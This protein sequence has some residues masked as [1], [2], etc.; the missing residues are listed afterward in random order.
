MGCTSSKEGSNVEGASSKEAPNLDKYFEL[1]VNE[2]K[3]MKDVDALQAAVDNAEDMQREHRETETTLHAELKPIIAAAFDHHDTKRNGILDA[4]ESKVFFDH[5]LTRFAQCK[6]EISDFSAQESQKM[7]MRMMSGCLPQGE[8]GK[9]MRASMKRDAEGK[10]KEMNRI[11]DD[12]LREYQANPGQYNESAFSL[13]DKNNDGR[14]VKDN[15]IAALLPGTEENVSFQD[16]FPF[17]PTELT[18]EAS[19]HLED[20]WTEAHTQTQ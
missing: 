17:T 5:Y 9:E 20:H 7:L 14:L 1:L 16:C 10:I 6:K 4:E 13:L 8:G 12:R 19:R 18:K 15:V 3:R 2:V 11:I